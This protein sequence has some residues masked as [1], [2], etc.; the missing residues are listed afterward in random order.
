MFTVGHSSIPEKPHVSLVYRGRRPLRPFMG[1]SCVGRGLTTSFWLTFKNRP[2]DDLHLSELMRQLYYPC[3][4]P[5]WLVRRYHNVEWAF[6]WRTGTLGLKRFQGCGGPTHLI[7]G[8]FNGRACPGLRF[9]AEFT[10]YYLGEAQEGNE[11]V[12]FTFARPPMGP[13]FT[14]SYRSTVC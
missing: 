12:S 1:V 10:A 2:E 13:P 3:H 8:R 5:N 4:T 7:P 6:G 14:S 11:R 9:R